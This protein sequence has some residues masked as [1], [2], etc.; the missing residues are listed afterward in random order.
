[1]EQIRLTSELIY[2]FTNSLLAPKFD[3]PVATPGCHLEWWDLMC[4]DS[5]HVAIA[6][7]R[8]HAKST[9]IT[10]CY[11]LAN[12]CFRVKQHILIVSDT[13]SQAVNFLGDIKREFTENEDLISL[14]EVEGLEKDRESEV[15][16]KFKDGYRVR[17]LAKGSLQALRGIK[18]RGM[19]PDLIVGDDL[20]N[21]EMV[22][23]DERRTKFREWFH[24]ALVPCKSKTGTVRIVGTILH[25]DSLLERFMPKAGDPDTI[26][27]EL[28]DSSAKETSWKAF[29]YKA[30]NDDFS[31]IL[32]P[33]Q[34]SERELKN[35]RQ[36]YIEDGMPEGYSQE[37]LNNP[38]DEATAYF[39]KKD[40]QEITVDEQ[41]EEFYVGIDLAISQKDRA[42]YTVFVVAGLTPKD[43]LRV[44]HVS[45]FRGDALEIIDEMFLIYKRFKP[46]IM[47]IEEENIARTLGPVINK[48]MEEKGIYLPLQTMTASQDK[49]K[50][51]RALQSRMRAGMIEVDDEA[52]WYPT[53]Q[54]EFLQFP[55]G[56]YMDQV[57]ST[58][59]IVLGLDKLFDTPTQQE[60]LDQVYEE[61]LEETS[62]WWSQSVNS[63]TGY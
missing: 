62:D 6:A 44:R 19:R 34:Y 33:E 42:A 26:S 16:I 49:Q 57:D 3:T 13:E 27:E 51:A 39:K 32:W 36:M 30:H 11:T 52:D 46:Q 18:W 8:G 35:I 55:R 1:M 21:D 60:Y 53:Y 40:F 56:A 10:H 15:V 59:W 41:P 47:F 63:T 7:P 5:K 2:G 22:M 14:F 29:R 4:S 48:A 17:I 9:A 25:M 37:Y 43:V 20:E 12:I 54:L 50:R 38:I 31:S 58:A 24:K 23:N 45:R 61:E 28:R